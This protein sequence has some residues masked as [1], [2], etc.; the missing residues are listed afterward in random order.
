MAGTEVTQK[1]PVP[2]R[3]ANKVQEMGEEDA[4]KEVVPEEAVTKD[5]SEEAGASTSQNTHH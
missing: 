5:V 2:L 3:R 1:S 4:T